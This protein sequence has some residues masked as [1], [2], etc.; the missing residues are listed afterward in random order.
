VVLLPCWLKL[1]EEEEK[2]E[3][4]DYFMAEAIF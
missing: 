4:E 2:E 1:K 3:K